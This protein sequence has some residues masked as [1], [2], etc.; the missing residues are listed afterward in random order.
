MVSSIGIYYKYL[1]II[2]Q[3][4]AHSLMVSSIGIYYKY[5]F[6]INQL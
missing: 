3:L 5:L 4:L 6:I 1:F 2:N